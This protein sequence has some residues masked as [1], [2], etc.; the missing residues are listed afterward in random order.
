MKPTISVIIPVYNAAATL[1]RCLDS[2]LT[3]TGC[4]LELL[5][6]NDG[7][8]DGSVD[9]LRQYVAKDAR[10]HVYS[11]E[12]NNGIVLAV[13]QGLREVS[14]EYVMFVDADDRLL[15]GAC[16]NALRLIRQY[17]V[18][19][20]QFGI[21]IKALPGVDAAG[22]ERL[23]RQNP[24]TSEGDRILYDCYSMH[25]FPHNIFN[26]IYRAEICREAGRMMPDLR[27]QQFTDLYLTFFFL[28]YAGSFR[29]V[30]DGPY[31]EYTYGSGVSTCA[32][33]AKQFACICSAGAIVPALESFLRQ[34]NALENNRFLLESIGIILKSDVVNKLLTLPEITKETVRMVVEHWGSD[35]LY[36]FIEATGLLAVPCKSRYR[37][38]LAMMNEIRRLNGVGAAPAK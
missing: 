25:R 14:G 23:F 17:G 21:A 28:Y 2:V 8:T 24:L 19:I 11:F 10:I 29:S 31:Y 7:S 26:K 34:E 6:I 12:K 1:A 4:D 3:Q 20:L 15:P 38:A 16:E 32:P 30:T 9:I 27:L 37:V 36:D 18:D 22:F 13:K 35:V 5:C 33:D